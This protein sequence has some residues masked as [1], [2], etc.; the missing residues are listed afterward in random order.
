MVNVA[1]HI[2]YNE[3]QES[4]AERIYLFGDRDFRF[5]FYFENKTKKDVE[6]RDL[7]PVC[8]RKKKLV[9]YCKKNADPFVSESQGVSKVEL[10][11]RGGSSLRIESNAACKAIFSF[12]ILEDFRPEEEDDIYLC[13]LDKRG[14]RHYAQFFPE[15]AG[16]QPLV[17]HKRNWRSK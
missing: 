8:L 17:F 12:S 7:H 15:L 16:K 3:I 4:Y 5:S 6:L 9:A 13:Y 10:F 2:N 1:K 11:E 14:N